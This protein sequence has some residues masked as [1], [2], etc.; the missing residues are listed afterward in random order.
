MIADVDYMIEKVDFRLY[1]NNR[2]DYMIAE[3]YYIMAV[4]GI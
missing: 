4:E 3:V 1:D 2:K